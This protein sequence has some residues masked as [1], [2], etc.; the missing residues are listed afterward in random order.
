MPR[1]QR[2][3]FHKIINLQTVGYSLVKNQS[4]LHFWSETLTTALVPAYPD[5]TIS[6]IRPKTKACGSRRVWPLLRCILLK[7]DW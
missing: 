1:F 5:P 4:G 3:I 7:L 6:A 2:R